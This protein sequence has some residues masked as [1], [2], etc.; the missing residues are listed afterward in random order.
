MFL[1]IGNWKEKHLLLVTQG[2]KKMNL[3]FFDE[4]KVEKSYLLKQLSMAITK[5]SF[6]N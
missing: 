4:L 2:N 5:Y 3:L 6:C 1:F